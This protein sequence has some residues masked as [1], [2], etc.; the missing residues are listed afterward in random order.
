MAHDPCITCY[1]TGAI[2]CSHCGGSGINRKSG[3]LDDP[4]L[5]CQG[6]GLEKC[7]ECRGTGEGR[8]I[9]IAATNDAEGSEGDL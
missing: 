5:G 3:L 4:C 9:G 7:Q 6:A 8:A 2:R 1:G